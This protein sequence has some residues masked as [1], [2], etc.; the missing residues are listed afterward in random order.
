MKTVLLTG[1]IGSG[2]SAVAAY[3]QERGIPVYDSDSR[4]KSLYTGDLLAALESSLHTSL[5]D[6]AGNFD[7][8]R[9]SARIF[10]NPAA[11]ETVESLVH[12]A[13]L[14]DFRQWRAA[15]EGKVPF[16]V[17]ESAIA[18]SKPLFDGLYDRVLLVTAPDPVRM[19]RALQRP[20]A[21]PAR[22]RARMNLQQF[23]LLRADA[24]IN[25][26]GDRKTLRE[27]TDIAVKMLNL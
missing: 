17:M 2:K 11:L 3:L 10:S 5:R 15:W 14:A 25:N 20:G 16:V 23:D 4:T 9:L 6:A 8:A 13:V 7:P 21:S 12:P 24:V 1:G 26:D 27:R 22:V 19:E 18:L